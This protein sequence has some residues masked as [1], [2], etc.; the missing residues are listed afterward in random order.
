[1][2]GLNENNSAAVGLLK[3]PK[4]LQCPRQYALRS[5]FTIQKINNT[6]AAV[7]SHVIYNVPKHWVIRT[8]Y[9]IKELNILY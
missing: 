8:S 2:K 9:K 7:R 1:M 6:I 4:T 5:I 3:N